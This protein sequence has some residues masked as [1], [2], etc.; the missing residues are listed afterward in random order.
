MNF[1]KTSDLNVQIFNSMGQTVFSKKM[2]NILRGVETLD[3]SRLK[4][5]VYI[6]EIS[7]GNIRTNKKLIISR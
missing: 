7:D 3:L 1:E 6:V 5:G 4:T 2:P